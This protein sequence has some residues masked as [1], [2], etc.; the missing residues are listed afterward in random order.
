[1]IC[2]GSGKF[3]CYILPPIEYPDG[4]TY[5]KLG[6]FNIT[7]AFAAFTKQKQKTT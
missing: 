2:E 5:L 6:K 3:G 7:F 1:M 4:K